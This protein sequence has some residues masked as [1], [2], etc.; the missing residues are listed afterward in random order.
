MVRRTQRLN[1]SRSLSTIQRLSGRMYTPA[2]N[3]GRRLRQ[4]CL[5]GLIKKARGMNCPPE[6]GQFRRGAFLIS[7]KST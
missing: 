5:Q 6:I 1:Y 2:G 4:P 3:N 7:N